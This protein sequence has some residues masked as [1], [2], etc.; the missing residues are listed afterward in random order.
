MPFDAPMR[1][2][3]RHGQGSQAPR[4]GGQAVGQTMLRVMR[5]TFYD[6][7][8]PRSRRSQRPPNRA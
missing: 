2:A 3:A 4:D 8:S 5:Q 6:A 1:P 7:T